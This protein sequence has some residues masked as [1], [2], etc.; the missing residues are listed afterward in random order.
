M[1]TGSDVQYDGE[2]DQL[3]A[4]FILVTDICYHVSFPKLNDR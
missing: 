1:G 4:S 3:T 2:A